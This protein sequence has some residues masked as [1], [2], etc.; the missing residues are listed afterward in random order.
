MKR[1][2]CIALFAPVR[3]S[4]Q[5]TASKLLAFVID[6]LKGY[7]A[8]YYYARI[9]H[10]L[11]R[12]LYYF[13]DEALQLADREELFRRIERDRNSMWCMVVN[14]G[15][16]PAEIHA[17]VFVDVRRPAEC[18]LVLSI[19]PQITRWVER[20]PST[21]GPFVTFLARVAK[22]VGASWLV[23]GPHIEKWRPLN[24][25]QTVNHLDLGVPYVVAWKSDGPE[26]AKLIADLQIPQEII[27]RTTLSYKFADYFPD[28]GSLG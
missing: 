5:E 7:L 17:G 9:M 28:Y 2:D 21:R 11:E 25:S 10:D 20:E 14:L 8:S 6:E 27:F 1:P 23:S 24:L 3:A 15:F 16:A 18:T 4:T 19:D 26:E 22:A 13:C 12:D